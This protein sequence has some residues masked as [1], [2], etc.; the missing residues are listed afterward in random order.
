MIPPTAGT[1]ADGSQFCITTDTASAV[2]VTIMGRA[3]VPE[4]SV[5]DPRLLATMPDDLAAAGPPANVGIF[6]TECR[7]SFCSRP[8]WECA[9]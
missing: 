9:G 3:L 6:G 5:T 4:I 8:S 7:I 1:A 2:K